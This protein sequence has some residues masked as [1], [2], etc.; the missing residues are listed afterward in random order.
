ME[1]YLKLLLEQIRCKEAH[2]YIE[3]E[4][5][6]HIEDQIE[7][8]M[9]CGMSESEALEEAIRDMGSP[10]ESGI[11]LD[12]VHRPAMNW[13]LLLFAGAISVLTI[14]L[15]LLMGDS[16]Y[17]STRFAF[18]TLIG[19]IAMLI[20]YKLDYSLIATYAKWIAGGILFV[21][22][23]AL[24]TPLGLRVNG[25]VLYL[26]VPFFS[27]LSI[28]SFMMLYVPIYG[29]L[30]YQYFGS[31]YR[32]LMKAILWMIVPC[33]L[34]AKLVTLSLALILFG[35]MAIVLSIAV[36]KEWF[37]I[38]KKK[39]FICFWSFIALL[40][41][42]I[43][44]VV[45]FSPHAP[46]YQQQRLSAFLTQSGDANYITSQL[47]NHLSQSK[48][49]GR[50]DTSLLQ[51]L[52]DVDSN[53]I[54]TYA[55]ASY[56]IIAGIVI[57]FLLCYLVFMIFRISF[58]QR[59]QLGMIM[60]T[61]CGTVILVNSMLNIFQNLGLLPFTQSFLPFFSSGGSSILICYIL[62]GIVLSVYKYKNIYPI[63]FKYA[64][65][66]KLTLKIQKTNAS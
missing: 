13:E 46:A 1:N 35:S 34:T 48:L 54:F 56:G 58:H 11:A 28:F 26:N 30:I 32:G 29:A 63:H 43:V 31:D 60:G 16:F 41:I 57:C 18:H 9:D 59:N 55:T 24:Y 12:K 42:A 50:I 10:V 49:I 62:L 61:G 15:H 20:V 40:P 4:I 3:S 14:I 36:Y 7:T 17:P 22:I 6:M 64:P 19:F 23:L 21:L 53:Y 8:N 66:I 51:L 44:T 25:S 39:F 27:N 52:P 65:K 45:L 5:R 33:F 2:P 38:N 47:L 37:H